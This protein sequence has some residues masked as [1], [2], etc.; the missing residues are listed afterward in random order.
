MERTVASV[1]VLLVLCVA[2]VDAVPDCL[3]FEDLWPGYQASGV[4][5]A[6]YQGFD[7]TW[8]KWMTKDN[9]PSSGYHN[10]I[11]G[12]VGIYTPWE[13]TVIMERD[14]PFDVYG[15]RVGAAWN[16]YQD[17]KFIGYLDGSVVLE[18]V[19]ELG[20][21]SYYGL[22][23]G[24]GDFDLPGLN[25]R[26]I[27]QLA[28]APWDVLPYATDHGSDSGSGDHICIDNIWLT[29]PPGSSDDSPEPATWLLLA[30]TGLA[31]AVARR[32]RS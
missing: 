6:G 32:R 10:T 24:C 27:D 3:D 19:V 25:F 17:V 5:T 21:Q 15:A 16:D 14:D 18:Q 26:G 2:V 11:E 22:D 20:A 1:C 8:G 31:G 30:C 13:Y 7:W 29:A 23:I 28:I 12:N 9:I 4:V